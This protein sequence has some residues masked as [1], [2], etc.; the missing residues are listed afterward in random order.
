MNFFKFRS[1]AFCSG[2][3]F[4]TI[5][6]PALAQ[7]LSVNE[8]RGTSISGQWQQG[9]GVVTHGPDG[10]VVF[11]F[12]QIQPSVVCSPLQV[13]DIELQPGE[14]VRDVLLGDTV[15]WKVEPATSG[16][17]GSQAVHL[18]VK[19]SEPGLVTSMVVTTS[20]RTYHIQ[21]KSHQTNYMARVGFEYPEDVNAR[22]AEIAT[23]MEASIVPGAGV[24][25]EQLN[26][27]FRV[28]G[29]ARWR[30]T[31]IYSDGQKTYIQFPSSLSGQDAPVLFVV[32]GGENRIV[33]YRMNGTMMVVDYYI[34]S[35]I[36]VSGVGRDQEKLT[37]RRGG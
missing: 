21:L 17:P 7:P 31:R 25:A 34:D 1:A 22:F 26:F 11:L 20:R 29:T 5:A 8:Q 19:P 36:L 32:S 27:S 24:P 4:S 14:I 10:K 16:A 2:L 30:P 37:I 18:I 13:C 6:V 3:V 9:Q 35:A 28:S 12:G 23:R 33:N 15:R